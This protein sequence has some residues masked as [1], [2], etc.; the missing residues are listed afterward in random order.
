V[1]AALKIILQIT[2]GLRHMPILGL[3][4]PM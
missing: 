1:A 3:W 2:P 4:T